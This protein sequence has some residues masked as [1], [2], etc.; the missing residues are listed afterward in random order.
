MRNLSPFGAVVDERE[1]RGREKGDVYLCSE[2]LPSCLAPV[3]ALWIVQCDWKYDAAMRLL[4]NNQ[5]LL[6]TKR[7]K[8]R[9]HF[10]YSFCTILCSE[11][12]H[13]SKGKKE[14]LRS[15]SRRKKH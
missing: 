11:I 9:H 12:C 4:L 1:G 6:S 7:D 8:L 10:V 3:L 14:V 2:K 15:F 5:D 13:P